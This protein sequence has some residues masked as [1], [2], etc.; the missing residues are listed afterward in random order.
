MSAPDAEQCFDQWWDAQHRRRMMLVREYVGGGP[1][2]YT[3][4]GRQHL[5]AALARGRGVILWAG[6]FASQTLAG[7]RGL[8]EA[9]IHAYQVSSQHHGFWDT[10]T[11]FGDRYLNRLLVRAEN[12]YLAGRLTFEKEDAGML[13]RKIMR[14]LKS[15]APVIL[16]NNLYAGRSFVEMPFGKAGFISMPTTPIA[17]A[18]RGRVPL[19]SWSTIEREPLSRYEIRISPDLAAGESASGEAIA[20]APDYP[21][22][23]RVALRV[24]DELLSAAMEAPDQFLSWPSLARSV[25]RRPD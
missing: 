19:L 18:L 14:T 2:R 13:V 7:K 10:Y 4:T 22:M 23:A 8:F 24:Q 15:G 11:R 20:A 6:P 12:R 5:D 1:V 16:T 21:A 25:L 3:L 9:G 17:L